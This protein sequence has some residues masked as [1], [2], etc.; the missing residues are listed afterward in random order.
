MFSIEFVTAAGLGF[1][2]IALTFLLC[3]SFFSVMEVA[4][5][6]GVTKEQMEQAFHAI[7]PAKGAQPGETPGRDPDE[8]PGWMNP[9]KPGDGGGDP[10]E[11]GKAPAE[12]GKEL[13]AAPQTP[14]AVVA[15]MTAALK[16]HGLDT[17]YKNPK[18]IV[19]AFADLE[20]RLTSA[21]DRYKITDADKVGGVL[22]RLEGNSP[23]TMVKLMEAMA[24]KLAVGKKTE[25]PDKPYELSAAL[26]SISE[27]YEDWS[28]EFM[29][30]FVDGLAEHLAGHPKLKGAILGD[31]PQKLNLLSESQVESVWDRAW[32]DFLKEYPADKFPKVHEL[33]P[34]TVIDFLDQN[35]SLI[36]FAN[37]SGKNPFKVAVQ[38]MMEEGKMTGLLEATA[39]AAHEEG[40]DAAAR[41]QA[42]TEISGAAKPG[43]ETQTKKPESEMT[44][45]EY[46]Q[47]KF[48]RELQGADVTKLF[49]SK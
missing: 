25:E 33:K 19:R 15:E 49:S 7:S 14:E 43:S 24:E 37:K 1:S 38:M 29:K 6:G 12:A 13:G 39:K 23:D 42:A 20:K 41:L 26:K 27:K 16:E 36:E 2:G 11:K 32:G 48:G 18:E 10:G 5:A 40:A 9:A 47:H 44:A 8:E 21:A 30:E 4:G 34:K 17:R 45:E 3:L 28:P 46:V 22:S 35:R 31:L